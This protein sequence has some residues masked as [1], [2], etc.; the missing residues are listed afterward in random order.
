M[1]K[2]TVWITRSRPGAYSS[3]EAWQAAG[4]E[5]YINPLIRI[6]IPQK[7]PQ[8]LEEN[9]VVLITSQNAL[10]S[11]AI[12]T[13]DRDWPILT[14]GDAS[15]DMARSMGFADVVSASGTAQDLLNMIPRLFNPGSP[16]IFVHASGQRVRRDLSEVLQGQGYKTRRDVYYNNNVREGIDISDAPS[17]THIALYSPMAAR[18]VR[19]YAGRV[20]KA[21]TVSI[22]ANTDKALDERYVNRRLIAKRPTEQAMIQVLSA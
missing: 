14:V 9:A 7:M 20:N 21:K 17:L 2:G 4:Y 13:D 19:K 12:L 3:A 1:R 18:A 15:A 16:R 5:T 22:S 6:G 11:L 8:P 10:R